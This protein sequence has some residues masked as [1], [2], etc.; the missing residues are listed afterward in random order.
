MIENNKGK[1]TIV[2]NF[3][4]SPKKM[5]MNF[6]T[7]R[8]LKPDEFYIYTLLI[9]AQ[10]D[11]V[12]NYRYFEEILECSN[13][14]VRTIIKSL[15]DKGLIDIQQITAFQSVWY[16][17]DVLLDPDK[18]KNFLNRKYNHYTNV[19]EEHNRNIKMEIA[20]LEMRLENTRGNEY[21]EIIDRIIKLEQS[22][23]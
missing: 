20:E 9:N 2:K 4:D 15:K 12:P 18:H 22:K 1:N 19:R 21:Q 8:R 13:S 5:I 23:K 3:L 7:M 10:D 11:F 6:E 14:R 16:V 17:N